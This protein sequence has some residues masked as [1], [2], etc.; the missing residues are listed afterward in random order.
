MTI[1]SGLLPFGLL[2]GGVLGSLT[3]NNTQLI[4]GLCLFS[5]GLLTIFTSFNLNI[6]NYMFNTGSSGLSKA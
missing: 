6:R 5:I 2:I 3:N 4:F 1:S